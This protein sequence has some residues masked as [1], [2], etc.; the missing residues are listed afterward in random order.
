[1]GMIQWP[2]AET[3]I[4]ER[5]CYH[6]FVKS[7]REYDGGVSWWDGDGL[8]L[9]EK[10]GLVGG[11]CVLFLFGARTWKLLQEGEEERGMSIATCLPCLICCFWYDA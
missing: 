3:Q 11:V 9:V 10:V 5:R 4:V 2:R 8:E 7:G 6:I 1:M